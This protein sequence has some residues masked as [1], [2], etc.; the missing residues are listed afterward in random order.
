MD[1]NDTAH[2]VRARVSARGRVV[3]PRAVRTHL[4]IAEGD[5]V[6]FRVTSGGTVIMESLD[7]VKARVLR[8]TTQVPIPVKDIIQ[9]VVL[10]RAMDTAQ[11][12][13]TES[14]GSEVAWY[15]YRDLLEDAL[16]LVR[17][18]LTGHHPETTDPNVCSCCG[19][20][21]PELPSPRYRSDRAAGPVCWNCSFE[22]GCNHTDNDTTTD[23]E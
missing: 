2:I 20:L 3:I 11:N 8:V 19:V 21:L 16:G 13:I 22:N 4:G 15:G 18:A 23:Q 14:G 7:Q 1:M 12:E 5:V 17:G 6:V 10:L 9:L